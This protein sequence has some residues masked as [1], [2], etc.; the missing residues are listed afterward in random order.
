MSGVWKLFFVLFMKLST[1]AIG[2]VRR[3]SEFAPNLFS[4]PEQRSWART[5]ARGRCLKICSAE[6][7]QQ[8]LRWPLLKYVG[9]KYITNISGNDS[10]AALV[11]FFQVNVPCPR[12]SRPFALKHFADDASE[13]GLTCSYSHD[14]SV[15]TGC[16]RV[17]YAG[18]IKLR[19]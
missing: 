10:L 14:R 1:L 15:A 3:T 13:Q 12:I 2:I 17:L 4:R 16:W 9:S 8:N 5:D 6:N 19:S 11:I 18:C 7:C